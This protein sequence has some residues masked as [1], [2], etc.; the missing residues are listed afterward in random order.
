MRGASDFRLKP[1]AT[2]ALCPAALPGLD[3]LTQGV[4]DRPAEAGSHRKRHP[5]RLLFKWLRLPA[6]GSRWLQP[7]EL[8]KKSQAE[9][10]VGL[11]FLLPIPG[12]S[13]FR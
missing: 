5:D 8:V 4:V 6:E 7:S 2:E 13:T 3:S 12:A 9:L 1:E 10:K 11:A